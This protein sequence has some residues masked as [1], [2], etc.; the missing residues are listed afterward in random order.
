MNRRDALKAGVATLVVAAGQEGAGAAEAPADDKATSNTV[1]L[2]DHPITHGGIQQIEHPRLGTT[3]H[4]QTSI[5]YLRFGQTVQVDRLEL[6]RLVYGRHVPQVPTHPAHVLV[7]VLEPASM[8]WKTLREVDLPPN[9]VLLGEGLT[10]DMTIEQMQE[11]LFS[12]LNEPACVIDLDGVQTDHLRVECD[13]EHPV[14]PNHGECNGG[15]HNVP[16][17]ILNEVRAY[18]I[19]EKTGIQTRVPP[20]VLAQRAIHPKAP[21]GMKVRVLPG[22]VMF[23]GKFLSIGFSLRR[24]MLM[25]LGW[26]ALGK[27]QAG[28]NRLYVTRKRTGYNVT[29]GVS[30]P[31]LRTLAADYPASLWSGEVSVEGNQI[32]YSNLR[33]VEGLHVD[34]VFTVEPDRFTM[35]LAQR[36]EKDM[37]V[38]EAEAWRLAWD[39]ALGI[40]GMAGMPTLRPGR[41]GDVALPGLWASDGVGCLACR[42][43][44]GAS[45]DVRMQVESYR[46]SNTVTGG[47]VFGE[48]PGPDVC[49]VVPAGACSAVFEFAIAN[50]NPNPHAHPAKASPGLRRHWATAF[51]CFRPE[52][53]GFSNHSASVNCHL[54]QGPPLEI[55]AHT[56]RPAVGPSPLDLARF[57]IERALLDG[58]GYGY[59]RNLYL[60][61]DPVLLCAAGRIHQADPDTKWLQKIEPGLLETVERMLGESGNEGMLVC[62]D[63]SGNLGS[64]RWSSNSMDV[65]GF[66]HIDAYVNAWAYRALRNAAAILEDLAAHPALA[67]RCRDTAARLRSAY[68]PALVNPETGWVAGWRSRDG[69]LHDYG[70]T[71]VNGVALAFGLLDAAPARTA[72]LNMERVRRETGL[73]DARLG[74]P[75]NL[76][77]IRADDQMWTKILNSLQPTFETYTDGSLSGWPATYYL[78]ALSIYGLKDEAR[79]LATELADGYAEGVFNGGNGSGHEFRSWEGLGT[80]YEGTLIGCF[81][82]LY[83]IAI[84]EG[85]LHPSNPEWWPENG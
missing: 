82:P 53:R 25:H 73:P 21:R 35:K 22:M 64:F 55:V 65:V 48:H 15:E 7:S 68:A 20:R 19:V 54:S 83:G 10:Q 5:R 38:I 13:R 39:L 3:V 33:A 63:L 59:H 32:V 51:S 46:E 81:G 1:Q 84:E 79:A 8:R 41:N 31:V 66:G 78:R 9:P 72:L 40:T 61:S 11:R 36:C 57:T 34:A 52:F 18:G 12:V 30:G 4:G 67:A 45:T 17:G 76:L 37:P 75:C 47:F 71:W 58:G 49:Q 27:G 60:D 70:F 23:E 74:L 2:V 14:W 62:K 50:L 69:Q 44:E 29:G 42:Q 56:Q 80:G 16:F 77:P 43:L 26:D 6:R 24:P 28:S 85:V